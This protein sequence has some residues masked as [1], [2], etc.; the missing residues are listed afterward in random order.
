MSNSGAA[1]KLAKRI[2]SARAEAGVTLRDLSETSGIAYSTLRRKIQVSPDA[3]TVKDT[4]ALALALGAE[5]DTF[6]VRTP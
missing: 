1:I 3:L 2:E 4:A 5:F 6:F